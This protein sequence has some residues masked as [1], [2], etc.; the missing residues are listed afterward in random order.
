MVTFPRLELIHGPPL[1]SSLKALSILI[2]RGNARAV[3]FLNDYD[4]ATGNSASHA[5]RFDSLAL[6]EIKHLRDG[7][8][9]FLAPLSHF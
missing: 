8:L 4:R 5:D 9:G 7:P 2:W 3:I 6:D 1:E